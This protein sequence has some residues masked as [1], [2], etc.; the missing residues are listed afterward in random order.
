MVVGSMPRRSSW[1][2]LVTR[3]W[4]A[5]LCRDL[6]RLSRDLVVDIT[7]KSGDEAVGKSF[8]P[9]WKLLRPFLD[10]RRG[11][12]LL[13]PDWA[14]YV[15]AYTAEMRISYRER[16]QAWDDVL[17]RRGVVLAC[18]CAD[19]ERCHRIVLGREILPRLGAV[20]VS[21]LGQSM[22]A[23]DGLVDQRPATGCDGPKERP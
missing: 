18:Y 14:A 1:G 6:G 9:S 7:R 11:G 4:T 10:K 12:R 22:V 17:G 23:I 2:Q 13:A 8:A 3:V 5:R 15:D 19:A 21:E 16:R 20:Y